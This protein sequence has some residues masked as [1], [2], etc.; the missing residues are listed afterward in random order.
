MFN[1]IPDDKQNISGTKG[2]TTP[3]SSSISLVDYIEKK[4]KKSLEPPSPFLDQL[5]V[6]IFEDFESTTES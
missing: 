2:G 5:V 1:K 3:A 4:T 6:S